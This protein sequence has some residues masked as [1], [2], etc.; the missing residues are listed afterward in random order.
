MSTIILERLF[1][2][3]LDK[4][5]SISIAERA[6][7]F[8]TD[9]CMIVKNVDSNLTPYIC[10]NRVEIQKVLFLFKDKISQK[11]IF[12]IFSGRVSELHKVRYPGNGDTSQTQI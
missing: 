8:K 1:N 7:K 5:G 9:E 10:L 11:H 4:V 12:Q 2:N 6:Y 3:E